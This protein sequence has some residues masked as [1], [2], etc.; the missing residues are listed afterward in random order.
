MDGLVIELEHVGGQHAEDSIVIA[1]PQDGAIFLGDCY[2]PPPTYLC[3]PDSVSSFY[4]L[5][6]LQNNVYNLY[7]EGHDKP[8]TRTELLKLLYENN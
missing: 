1:I 5:R 7:V 3:K 8:F 2:Y 4:M 6:N